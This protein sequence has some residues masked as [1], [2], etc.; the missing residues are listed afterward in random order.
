[1]KHSFT[2]TRNLL[3]LACMAA[4]AGPVMAQ[5][6]ANA[7]AGADAKKAA[8]LETVTVT[9]TRISNPNVIS[10]TPI[11]VLTAAEIKA[12]GAVNI[13]DLMTTMPQLSTTFTMGNSGR[14]IGTAGVAQ[15]D[16]RN[17]GT[18]RTLVLVNGRRFVGSSAGD[19]AVDLNSSP[20][21]GSNAW[22][23]S[24]VAP[25]PFTVRMP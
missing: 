21:T 6:A 17:L 18:S 2:H 13:G 11:S 15:Q 9:G 16:L 20:P 10:P 7:D 8:N 3:A 19:T 25:R 1:M 4:L 12:T 5:D 24:P 23:S 22:K 14:F